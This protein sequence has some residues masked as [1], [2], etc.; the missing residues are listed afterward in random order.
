M[1][2][3]SSYKRIEEGGETAQAYYSRTIPVSIGKVWERIRDF[4]DD[5]WS[6]DVTES[7]SENGQSGSTVGTVRVHVFD[8]KTA[9]SVQ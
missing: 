5:R 2:L 1:P 4:N 3:R 6:G 8:G 7:K 9:R